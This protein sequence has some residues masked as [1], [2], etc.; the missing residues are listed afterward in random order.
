MQL[1][2]SVLAVSGLL[3]GTNARSLR[4][5]GKNYD[6]PKARYALPESIPRHQKRAAESIIQTEAAKSKLAMY[7]RVFATG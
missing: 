7:R 5:V 1:I 4:S 3:A 2:T 6:L